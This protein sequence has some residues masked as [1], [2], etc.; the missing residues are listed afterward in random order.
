MTNTNSKTIDTYETSLNEYIQNTPSK[1]GAVVENW[2]DKGLEGAGLDAK[3][4]EVGSAYGRDASYVE[5]KGYH[6]EKTDATQGFVD[7]LVEKDPTSHKLNIITDPI[8]EGY[9]VVL[10]NAVLL[11]LNDTET[12]DVLAK[13]YN[14]LKPGGAFAF[15][16]KQGDGE[17]W[18]ENKG[19]GPRFFNYWQPETIQQAL[20]LAGFTDIQIWT[21]D[22]D[23]PATIWIMIVARRAR[24]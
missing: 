4:L 14:G 8:G 10:A 18:Q 3:I 13:I 21:D 12:R 22:T 23:G 5:S 9:D 1:R 19:M 15:T 17:A 16:L 6:V 2:L 24:E 7:I 20:E 11:H